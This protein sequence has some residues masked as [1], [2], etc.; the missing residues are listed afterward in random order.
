MTDQ[1]YL[2]YSLKTKK[3]FYKKL[4]KKPQPVKVLVNRTLNSGLLVVKELLDIPF[5]KISS[6][7]YFYCHDVAIKQFTREYEAQLELASIDPQRL[8]NQL[9]SFYTRISKKIIKENL[10]A[11][12]FDFVYTCVRLRM[13]N[14]AKKGEN[15]VITAYVNI[16]AQTMEYIRPNKFD[17][18]KRVVGLSTARELLIADDYVP[19]FD[20][21]STELENNI[22]KVYDFTYVKKL[23]AK[24][25]ISLTTYDDIEVIGNEDRAIFSMTLA[26]LPFINEYTYDVLPT[27][28]K[29]NDNFGLSTI[30]SMIFLDDLK[31]L[32][33]RRSKTLPANGVVIEFPQN[34]EL[35]KLIIKECLYQDAIYLLYRLDTTEGDYCGY[36]DTKTQ[37]FYTILFDSTC[38]EQ[39]INDYVSFILYLYSCFVVTNDFCRLE[40]T[41]E[42]FS[43][44]TQAVVAEG[45]QRGGKLRPSYSQTG[46]SKKDNELYL[47]EDRAIQGYIRNLPYGQSPSEE[48]RKYAELLGYDLGPSETY[49]RPFVKRVYRLRAK[50]TEN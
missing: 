43:I 40:K 35:N 10:F 6:D 28:F 31:R 42:F 19:Y 27:R 49:V 18:S 45:Y 24:Y 21:A 22:E 7:L 44:G 12:F 26:M 38:S 36:Y 50:D 2:A 1:E 33:S 37:F 23:Y 16:L 29:I 9:H 8:L 47:S 3:S 4:E 20:L 5:E 41:P 48:A 11:D 14:I 25:G 32:L 15:K 39:I 30:K 34:I 17:F 46:I 13:E